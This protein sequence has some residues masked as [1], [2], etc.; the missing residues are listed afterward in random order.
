VGARS[1]SLRIAGGSACGTRLIVPRNPDVRP[2]TD[3]LRVSLFA[4]LAPALAGKRVLDLFAGSGVLGL[5]ALSRGAAHAT[6][7]DHDRAALRAL[8]ENIALVGFPGR[9]AVIEAD[10]LADPGRALEG[11][12]AADLTFID[13]PFAWLEGP[14]Q[15][16]ALLRLLRRCAERLLVP[17]GAVVF[18]YEDTA[19]TAAERLLAEAGYGPSLVRS[20]GRSVVAIARPAER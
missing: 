9:T 8:R 18:R 12:P 14:A 17:G 3:R 2:A 20:Y 1:S 4:T 10:L 16:A 19:R 11:T 15:T 6:F 7:V 13:P 5:E